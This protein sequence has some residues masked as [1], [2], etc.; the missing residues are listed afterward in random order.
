MHF[1]MDIQNAYL[2]KDTW[3]TFG[4]AEKIVPID[5]YIVDGCAR[6]LYLEIVLLCSEN[7]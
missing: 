5:M 2:A 6:G 7:F 3:R 4:E 1:G